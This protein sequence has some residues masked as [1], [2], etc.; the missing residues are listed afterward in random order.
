MVYADN[1]GFKGIAEKLLRNHKIGKK[2]GVRLFRWNANFLNQINSTPSTI[3]YLGN[4]DSKR[5]YH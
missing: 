3:R 4:T 5:F 1:T 2:D